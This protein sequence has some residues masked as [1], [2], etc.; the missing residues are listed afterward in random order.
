MLKMEAE[1]EARAMECEGYYEGM[2][3]QATPAGTLVYFEGDESWMLDGRPITREVAVEAL[4][5][6]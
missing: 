1:R 4:A 6:R 5:T 2:A 3:E